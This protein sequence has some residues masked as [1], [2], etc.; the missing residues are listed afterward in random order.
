M[1]YMLISAVAAD[2]NVGAMDHVIDSW[3]QMHPPTIETIYSPGDGYPSMMMGDCGH[4]CQI[5]L[6][7]QQ[8]TH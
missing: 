3:I 6:I 2:W 1:Q 5:N 8:E 4:I 7:I